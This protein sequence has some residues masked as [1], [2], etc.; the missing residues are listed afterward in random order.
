MQT[1]ADDAVLDMQRRLFLEARTFN[2]WLDKPVEEPTLRTIYE[3]ARMAPTSAN[4]HPGRILFV[5][6][7]AGKERLRPTLSPHNVDKTMQAPATAVIAYDTKFHE[8][9]PKLFPARPEFG[10]ML[11][12]MPEPAKS[13]FLMQ[14]ASLLGGYVILAARSLGLDCGPMGGFDKDKLDAEFFT[15]STWRST[16]LINI[17]YG[18]PSSLWPRNPRL[19]FEE[20]TRTV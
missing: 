4:S 1:P 13:I 12:A 11:G 8:A 19:D 5:T 15:D 6:S 2:G 20:A 14:N 18:N 10:E 9:M 16:M 17:G 7:A 3:L